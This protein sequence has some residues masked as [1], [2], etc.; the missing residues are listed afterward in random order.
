MK[1]GQFL[2]IVVVLLFAYV[3]GQTGIQEKASGT[4]VAYFLPASSE[5]ETIIDYTGFSLLYSETH[6]QAVWVAYELTAEEVHTRKANR[7]NRFNEDDR[8]P[9]GSA[10]NLDYYKSGFD[11]GHLAPAADMRFSQQ[12]MEESFLYS[13]ISP[14]RPAFNRGIWA[15]LED[16]TREWAVENSAISIVTGPVLSE[17]KYPTIGPNEVSVPE[18][19]FKVILDH[20]EPE[21]K[22]IGFLI[23]NHGTDRPMSD[24]AR[25]VREIEQVTGLDFFYLLDDDIEE[26]V[27][28]AVQIEL[29][30]L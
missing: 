21:Y 19:F 20:I 9:T 29:W 27:E 8:I 25:S 4:Q 30:G 23:P 28:T 14:Q 7:L 18:F 17:E 1:K 13:N 2:R 12:A 15:S 5:H 16:K 22:A 11:R 24:Y 6:E 3:S 26:Q 10:S